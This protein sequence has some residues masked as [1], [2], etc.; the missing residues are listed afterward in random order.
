MVVKTS[1]ATELPLCMTAV[2]E[3]AI[4]SKSGVDVARIDSVVVEYFPSLS[5][6]YRHLLSW[7]DEWCCRRYIDCMSNSLLSDLW[8]IQVTQHLSRR[9]RSKRDSM[10]EIIADLAAPV[11]SRKAESGVERDCSRHVGWQRHRFIQATH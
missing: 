5:E 3:G 7:I 4:Q 6:C 2:D 11:P 9:E 1:H 8:N 10:L